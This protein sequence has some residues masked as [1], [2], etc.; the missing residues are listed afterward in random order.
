M[1][2]A[3][4]TFSIAVTVPV[5]TTSSDCNPGQTPGGALE[6]VQADTMAG[7][8]NKIGRRFRITREVI[9]D[10]LHGAE[11]GIES[12]GRIFEDDF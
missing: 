12:R 3:A 4:E 5:K 2:A 7:Q 11:C 8:K 9:V 6:Q 1:A 10:I